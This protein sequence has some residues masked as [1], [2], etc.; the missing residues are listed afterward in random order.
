M[1]ALLRNVVSSSLDHPKRV[2]AVWAALIG[3]S[4]VFALQLDSALSAGG[5]TDPRAEAI[6]TQ[7]TVEEAFGEKP[8]Q[9]LVVIDSDSAL[10]AGDFDSAVAVLRDAGAATVLTP[11]SRPELASADGMTAVLVAGFDGD[12]SAVQNLTPAL[13]QSLDDAAHPGTSVYLTGQ[14]AL[15]YELN[16]HSK[17]DAVRAELIVFP[18]LIIVLLIVFRSVVATA[19]PLVMAGSALAAASA[20]GFAITRLTPVSVLYSNIVSMIGLAV[21]IDY[22]L[23]VIK[24]YREELA[25][26]RSTRAALEKAFAT[27][28]HSVLFSGIAVAVALTALL[29]PGLMAFTSIALGG[30]VVTVIALLL[31]LTALPAALLLIGDR[32]NW[33]TPRVLA[34]GSV[35]PVRT[36]QPRMLIGLAAVVALLALAV[37]IAGISLQS[38]VAS[39]TIL[40]A[41]DKARIGLQLAEDEIGNES[42]FPIQVVVSAPTSVGIAQVLS[43][44]RAV[45]DF[46]D[47]QAAVSAVQSVTTQGATDAQL[48]QALSVSPLPEHLASAWA[49]RD[50]RWIAR[51]MVTASEGP[52]SIAAH[53]LVTTMRTSAPAGS[54]SLAVTGATAQGVDFDRTLLSSIPWIVLFVFALTFGMLVLAFRSVLLPLLAL[55]FN[56]LVVLAS[57]G[58]LTGFVALTG[59]GEINSVTPVLLFAVMFGLSMDYMVII[60]SRIIE[61]FESG[62]PF[63]AAVALGT[64]RT[65]T[66][67]NSAAIIMI[68][69]FASFASAQISIVRE[70]GIGLGVAV[71]LDALAIRVLVM[72]AVLVLIGPRVLGTQRGRPAAAPAAPVAGR[73]SEIHDV[74]SFSHPT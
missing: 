74:I 70:I 7:T 2:I 59:G 61:A 16:M 62:E 21:A 13:Q 8:N 49:E 24:R 73:A 11:E 17:E 47:S 36:R 60:I 55:G 18:V 65:R 51:I 4:V 44:I 72:P 71:L 19:V 23:F 15:D 35:G 48:A 68:A 66:M 20:I 27:A 30:I 12:N 6:T 45:S 22:S 39:A 29:I 1:R 69:V 54:L 56:G 41:D 5:F 52:D 14:P 33:G 67:I 37:P 9:L 63:A 50:G 38:P 40:P 42:L 10:S 57:L 53:E 58:V 43:D 28:G 31:T 34:R 32:I 26:G 3:I 46:A 64:A 25:A